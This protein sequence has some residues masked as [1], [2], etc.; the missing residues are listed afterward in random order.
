MVRWLNAILEIVV[1][2]YLRSEGRKI[3][4]FVH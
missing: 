4:K 2:Y 1:F 3:I